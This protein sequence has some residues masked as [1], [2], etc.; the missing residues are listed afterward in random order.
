MLNIFVY[1]CSM[2]FYKNRT[3]TKRFLINSRYIYT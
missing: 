2:F 1:L 3:I